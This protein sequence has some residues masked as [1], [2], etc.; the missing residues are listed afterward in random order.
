MSSSQSSGGRDNFA[1]DPLGNLLA[2]IILVAMIIS[3]G[4][5]VIFFRR[6]P[7]SH[8][9]RTAINTSRNWLIPV[10][11]L[12]GLVVTGY[13]AYV[14]ITQVEAV[15]GPVGDCNTV[16]QSQ[17]ARLFGILPIGVLG[18]AGYVTILIAWGV[19]R[20]SSRRI[21]AYASLALLGFTSFGV[22]F[23]IYLTFL[24]PFVIGATCAWCLTS[25]LIITAI[26]WLTLLPARQVLSNLR[27]TE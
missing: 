13:L 1:R 7:G 15:C 3:V 19:S 14:E 2:V 16:Q 27:Y 26:F 20:N 4:G 5:A 17:Y 6:A 9:L 24:E 25:S 12:I 18:L 8:T 10:L 11:C 22:L 23:S 21:A